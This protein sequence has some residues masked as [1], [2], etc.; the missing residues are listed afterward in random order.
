M[1]VKRNKSRRPASS[2]EPPAL[3]PLQHSL[4]KEADR[5]VTVVSEGEQQEV[6]IFEVVSRK[7]LQMAAGGSI[8]ALSNAVNEINAAQQL[9]QRLIEDE[10]AFGEKYK[11][12]QQQLLDQALAKGENPE[13]ILPHPDDIKILPGKGFKI[14]GPMD[15]AEL[16]TIRKCCALRDVLLLQSALEVRICEPSVIAN[17]ENPGEPFSGALAMVLTHI[18]NN[19]LPERFQKSDAL[20]ADDFLRY[21][22]L[23]KRELLKE[24]HRAWG[25][26]GQPKPRAWVLPP[27]QQ[28]LVRI[29]QYLSVCADIFQ[30]AQ[31]GKLKSNREIE[32]ELRSRIS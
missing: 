19:S 20:L 24:T 21:S 9:Q 27:Y 8:H 16:E 7:L 6:N 1:A 31:D 32:A 14:A 11:D 25:T 15:E 22:R 30:L 3:T 12:V 26:I 4:L 29:E 10:V 2:T 13:K 5:K 28:S 18:I 23:T 17:H